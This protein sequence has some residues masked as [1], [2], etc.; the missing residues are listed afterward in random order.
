MQWVCGLGA[1]DPVA[2]RPP[3]CLEPLVTE[4]RLQRS[5]GMTSPSRLTTPVK[6]PVTQV[7]GKEW[8][9][10]VSMEKETRSRPECMLSV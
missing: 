10:F 6:V 8:V 3:L 4:M 1:P 9:L 2:L 7:E 5:A